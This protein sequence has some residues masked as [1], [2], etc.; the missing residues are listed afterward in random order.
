MDLFNH[1]EES[2][3]CNKLLVQKNKHLLTTMRV[4]WL[5]KTSDEDLWVTNDSLYKTELLKDAG[6][7]LNEIKKIKNIYLY[8]YIYIY[9]SNDK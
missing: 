2:Y 7:Q 3:N 8:K 1:I 9:K 4:V 6:K 5:S